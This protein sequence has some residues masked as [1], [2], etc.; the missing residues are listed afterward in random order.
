MRLN[1][2]TPGAGMTPRFLSGREEILSEAELSLNG[3]KQGYMQRPV[4]YYGLRGVGKTVILNALAEFAENI[5]IQHEHIEAGEDNLFTQRFSAAVSRMLSNLGRKNKVADSIQKCKDLIH[6]FR[7]T[8]EPKDEKFA[9]EPIESLITTSGVYS[10]DMMQVIVSLGRAAQSSNGA[11][12]FFI[13]EL[14][15]LNEDEVRGLVNGIHRCNQ[16]KLPVTLYCAGLPKVLKY[17]GDICSYSERLF[18]FVKVDSLNQQA[19][20]AAVTSPA[21][22]VGVSF[23][24]D[25]LNLIY[26]ITEGYPYFIQEFCSAIFDTLPVEESVVGLDMVSCSIDKFYQILDDGFFSVR[27]DRCTPAEKN[28]VRAMVQ[29]GSLPC[30]ISKVADLLNRTLKQISPVRGKLISKGVIYATGHGLID[31]TVPQFNKFILRHP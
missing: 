18:G 22:D 8:Y 19:S 28:F 30:E 10:E 14:Q 9:I 26:D 11:V 20:F 24:E 4:I 31:F 17:V 25:A 1:P 5:G 3:L 27:F 7:L 21:E 2:Y 29:C 15:Y 16:L 12:C 6:S 13:D 23:T